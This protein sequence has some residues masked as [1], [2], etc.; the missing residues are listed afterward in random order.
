[1][2]F[3]GFPHV[4]YA[5]TFCCQYKRLNIVANVSVV[6]ISPL[7]HQGTMTATVSLKHN[8]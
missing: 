6:Q 5:M 1:M 8:V 7:K 3:S 4:F 2:V